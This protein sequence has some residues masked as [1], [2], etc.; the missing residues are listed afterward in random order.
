[1]TARIPIASKP[2]AESPYPIGVAAGA[3]LVWVLNA[4]TATVTKIDP[5][6]RG[7]AATIQLGVQRRPFRLAAGD[8]AAWV[9]DGDG[10]LA[11]IDATTDQVEIVPAAGSLGDVAVVGKTIWVTAGAGPGGAAAKNVAASASAG[12]VRALPASSCSPIYYESGTRPQYLIVGDLTLQGSGSALVSQTAEAVQFILKQHRFHAGRYVVGYQSC[13]NSTI[14]SGGPVPAKCA[15]N[16]R[17]YAADPS[18]IGIIGTSSSNCSLVELPIANSAP[19]GPLAM[20]SPGDTYVGLTH[21]GPG[22]APDEPARYYPTGTRSYVRLMAADDAQGA[23]DA[24]AA[25]RLGARRVFVLE[26]TNTP[27]YSAGIAADFAR[28]ARRLGLTVVGPSVWNYEAKSYTPFVTRVAR[29]HPDAVFLGT[30]L[31]PGSVRLIKDLRSA[32]PAGALL[33]VPDGF[34]P[35]DLVTYGGAA[36]E[37]MTV[38]VAG[39]P[40]EQLP[41]RGRRFVEDFEQATGNTKPTGRHSIVAA[42]ATEVLLDAIARSDGTRASVVKQLFRTRVTNGILGSFGFD[43]NGDTT[44]GAVT[45][46]R[47]T[48]GSPRIFAVITPPPALVR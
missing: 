17:A 15:A 29:S 35:S 18:V 1:M 40:T 31:S 43:R 36:A 20:V 24:L 6:Q 19:D 48:H 27:S 46:Y 41:A 4:N 47:I 32:L 38:S 44:A 13:D 7:V 3:G 5:A 21:H 39:L 26:D 16:A 9:A 2:D 10:T 25:R 11:R 8:G 33:M 14:A 12:R 28:A 45:V 23:A 30:F 22:T 37:G 42:Q 34:V